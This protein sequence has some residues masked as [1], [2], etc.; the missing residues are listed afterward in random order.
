MGGTAQGLG[1]TCVC[2]NCGYTTP[3]VRGSPCMFKKCPKCGT[4]LVRE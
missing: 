2:P 3:H 1:G 4:L